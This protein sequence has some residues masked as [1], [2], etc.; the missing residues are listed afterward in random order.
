MLL[1]VITA[2]REIER[3]QALWRERTMSANPITT[4]RKLGWK[5]QQSDGYYD[6][7]WNE[8]HRLWVVH[9]TD[10]HRWWNPCGL[11]DPQYVDSPDIVVEI[12]PPFAG[13]HNG[14]TGAFARDEDGQRY[15]IHRG[16]LGGGNYP[17]SKEMFFRNFQG[18]TAA[19]GPQQNRKTVAVVASLE[20]GS[21]HQDLAVFVRECRRLKALRAS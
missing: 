5:G 21:F 14:T 7:H 20:D 9:A 11:E 3:A 6:L 13:E 10:R 19:I 4:P 2:D 17:V 12:N 16:W 15:I 8:T 18:Q 1:E